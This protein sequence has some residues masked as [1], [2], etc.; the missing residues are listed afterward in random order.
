LLHGYGVSRVQDGWSHDVGAVRFLGG[1]RLLDC[2]D[3]GTG[4]LLGARAL[5]GERQV[6]TGWISVVSRKNTKA[7]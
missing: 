1:L 7:G 4:G 3:V 6:V 2:G 5:G